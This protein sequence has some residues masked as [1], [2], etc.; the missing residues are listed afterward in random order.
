MNIPLYLYMCVYMLIHVYTLA[1]MF[2]Y[3]YRPDGDG[4]R[5][6]YYHTNYLKNTSRNIKG[7]LLLET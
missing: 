2:I 7:K 3:L 6:P 1:Y 4:Q 5:H